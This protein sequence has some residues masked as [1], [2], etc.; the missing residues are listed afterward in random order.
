MRE[1][2]SSLSFPGGRM[3]V[4]NCVAKLSRLKPG[5]RGSEK[6]GLEGRIE[7]C[8]VVHATWYCE[9]NACRHAYLGSVQTGK[10]LLIVQRL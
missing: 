3:R 2:E 7:V 5:G 4:R 8:I 1:F 6:A 9:R 10:F